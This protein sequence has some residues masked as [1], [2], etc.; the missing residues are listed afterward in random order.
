M[1]SHLI[2][3]AFL[4]EHYV[5]CPHLKAQVYSITLR[6]NLMFIEFSHSLSPLLFRH[7]LIISLH[8]LKGR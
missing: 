6:T 4:E 8:F 1:A 5:I 7:L 2:N 3:I